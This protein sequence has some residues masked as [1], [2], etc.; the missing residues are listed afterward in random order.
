MASLL[1]RPSQLLLRSQRS[2][3]SSLL[4]KAPFSSSAGNSS[5][6]SG[7]TSLQK[8]SL[9]L[10]V[11]FGGGYAIGYFFGPFPSLEDLTGVKAVGGA[12]AYKGELIVTDKVFFDIG[13]NDDYVGKIVMGL[14]GEVQPRTVENFRALC[15][16]EKGASRAGPPLWYKDSKFH[17]I[18]PGFMIQG[19]DFTQHNGRGGESIYGRRFDDEDLSVPHAGPGTLSMANAGANTN[20]SQFFI[21]TGDTPWLD[22]KHVVFGRVLEGMDVVDIVSSCGKRSGKPMVDVKI[23]NC[24][25]LDDQ[26][27]AADKKEPKRL[28]RDEMQDRLDSL[29]E[30][31]GNFKAQKDQID[32]SMY[33]QL[34]A[35]IKLE[36]VRIK[37]ELKKPQPNE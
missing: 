23:I 17:R 3:H 9:G 5:S 35:E 22:G 6:P 11:M 4:H 27:V 16:G 8:A 29:R 14:Y 34:M 7:L 15:T 1:L 36:K 19:G 24:G 18:V 20:G 25:V 33:D 30:V 26:G 13:I 37:K 12:P 2:A 10:A 28:T 21:C 32:P 31:E